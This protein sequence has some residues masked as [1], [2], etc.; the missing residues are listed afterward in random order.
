MWRK[1]GR[2]LSNSTDILITK[3]AAK[4]YIVSSNLTL[5]NSTLEDIGIYECNAANELGESTEIFS[6]N[7]YG[8]CFCIIVI[9]FAV[10]VYTLA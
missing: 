4:N 5:T 10:Q 7:I 8:R 9:L 1:N 2:V 3:N 6:V